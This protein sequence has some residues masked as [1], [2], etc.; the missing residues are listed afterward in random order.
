MREGLDY[1]VALA[2]AVKFCSQKE[3][4]EQVVRKKLTKWQLAD[5][6]TEKVI[7]YLKEEKY[8]DEI[9][10]ASAY[11]HDKFHFYNWGKTKI[12]YE[13]RIRDI[14]SDI[15][16]MAVQS[17]DAEVYLERLISLLTVRLKNIKYKNSYDIKAKLYRFGMSKGFESELVLKITENIIKSITNETTIEGFF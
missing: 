3:Q 5:D 2:K 12:V 7:A 4:C 14:S 8:L 1:D 15:A 13:L 6:K 10:F 11:A 16:D 17:I 9:R